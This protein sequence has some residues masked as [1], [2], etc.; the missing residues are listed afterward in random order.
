[1]LRGPHS[2]PFPEP[3]L[4]TARPYLSTPIAWTVRISISVAK[5]NAAPGCQAG[6]YCCVQLRHNA[7]IA[8]GW[9]LHEAYVRP[10][11][12]CIEWLHAVPQPYAD[13]LRNWTFWITKL[14]NINTSYPES[15]AT[16]KPLWRAQVQY[17]QAAVKDLSMSPI[18]SDL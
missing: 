14:M 12:P 5:R 11:L 17:H 2:T 1:M 9:E 13:R 4:S 7:A 6:T 3:D 16:H 10:L 8:R 15:Y 18:I